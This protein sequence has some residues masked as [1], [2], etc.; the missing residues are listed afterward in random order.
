MVKKVYI[1]TQI[2]FNVK[3]SQSTVS[4]LHNV[5]MVSRK[6]VRPTPFCNLSLSTERRGAYTRDATF[7]LTITPSLYREILSGSVVAGFVLAQP[8]H[9]GDLEPDCVGVWMRGRGL[10]R[11]IKIPPQDFALK[12][13]RR[14]MHEG[15]I[16]GTLW[17][18]KIAKKDSS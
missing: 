9:Y 18:F 8:F 13:Q 7:A 15:H 2:I 14:L 10:M 4:S 5:T 3:I 16:C 17:Y 1:F 12:M 11:G 6:Y